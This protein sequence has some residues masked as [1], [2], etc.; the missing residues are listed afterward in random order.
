MLV[1]LLAV[2]VGCVREEPGLYPPHW[3]ADGSR[4]RYV[5]ARPDGTLAVREVDMASGTGAELAYGQFTS[6]PVV[7]APS[8]QGD[9]VACAVLGR[10]AGRQAV[11]RLHVLSSAGRT[12]RVLWE[13]PCGEGA[14]ELCWT[15]DGRWVLVSADRPGGGWALHRVPTD[16]GSPQ[17]LAADLFEARS[18]SVSPDALR[19]AFVGRAKPG[20][21]WALCVAT[22]ADGAHS[23]AVPALFRDYAVG[24]WPAWSPRGDTVAYV[25]ERCLCAGLAEVAVWSPRNGECRVVARSYAG[26]CLAPAW[27]PRGDALACVSLPFAGAL[28]ARGLPADIVMVDAAGQMQRV[29]AADGLANVMPA[30]SPDGGSV[31]FNT[32]CEAAAAHCRQRAPRPHVVRVAALDTGAVRLAE[33]SPEARFVLDLA[34]HQSRGSPTVGALAGVADKVADPQIAPFAHLALAEG[35]ASRHDWTAAAERARLASRAA[36]TEAQLAALRL[37][38]TAQMRL[39]NPKAALETVAAILSK[40]P[41]DEAGR[42]LQ[43]ALVQGIETAARLEA[44]IKEEPSPLLLQALADTHLR[45][46]GNPRKALEILFRIP[47]DFPSGTHLRP[48]AESVLA[49]CAQLGPHSTSSRVLE[50]AA[51]TLGREA[52]TPEQ[53]ALLASAAADSGDAR[54]ALRWLERLAAAGEFPADVGHRAAEAGL[55]AAEQFVAAGASEDAIATYRLVAAMSPGGPAAGRASLEAAKLLAQRGEHWEA[56]Q[57]CLDALAPTAAV[58]TRREALRLLAAAR[59]QRRDPVAYDI[60]EV[61]ELVAFG[62]HE[63]AV[64]RGEALARNITPGDPQHAALRGHVAAA[65]DRLIT[66]H[67][68]RGDAAGRRPVSPNV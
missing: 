8:P 68:A 33:D 66:W 46:L 47:K 23:V 56:A 62:F 52:L 26:A 14:A 24:Y 63:A 61:A 21:L 6:P 12:D 65:F 38:A 37:L 2:A 55:R 36:D 48:A 54:G 50:W 30:W 44:E 64:A 7:I 18:P 60:A 13:A 51:R 41:D 19:V 58:A 17:A 34:R 35:F 31:A 28:G 45:Q 25:A 27:S 5:A 20:E 11:L 67:R 40:R 1:A 4:L 10:E 16:G 53:L 32:L 43:Q 22:L 15:F 9:K 29:L 59:L 57:R 49:A 42:T 39:G 3:S